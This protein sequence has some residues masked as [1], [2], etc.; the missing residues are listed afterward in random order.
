MVVRERIEELHSEDA[1]RAQ[2]FARE[3]I[4]N[5]C[6]QDVSITD[7]AVE[8]QTDNFIGSHI[9]VKNQHGTFVK[10]KGEYEFTGEV[11]LTL[12]MMGFPRCVRNHL[13]DRLQPTES[14]THEFSRLTDEKP[15][16]ESEPE[17]TQESTSTD[18]TTSSSRK[19]A[20]VFSFL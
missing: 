2:R 6:I 4:N 16:E 12:T 1:T 9:I 3:V 17:T 7:S 19:F 18:Q 14:F 15:Q 13:D 20:R 11:S 5:E 10:H 8:V